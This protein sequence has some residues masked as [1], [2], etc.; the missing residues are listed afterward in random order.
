ML[1]LASGLTTQPAARRIKLY[2][3]AGTASLLL[4]VATL[5]ATENVANYYLGKPGK[6]FVERGH[7]VAL[8]CKWNPYTASFQTEAAVI[9]SRKTDNSGLG[10]ALFKA[11]QLDPYNPE[12]TFRLACF[13]SDHNKKPVSESLITKLLAK[14]PN[15]KQI[16]NSC[17]Q[18]Y[19]YTGDTNR[20]FTLQQR[21][22]QQHTT[23]GFNL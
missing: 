22:N 13:L 19:N 18:Y 14:S 8:A 9:A 3:V 16:L 20:S 10:H 4:I 7:Y 1:L 11:Y 17:I 12:I 6:T 15:N 21:L 2:T 23:G 5:L